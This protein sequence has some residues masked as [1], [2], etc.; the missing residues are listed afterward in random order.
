VT[1]LHE[2]TPSIPTLAP[3]AA[4]NA[5][6]PRLAADDP[7]PAVAD[8]ATPGTTSGSGDVPADLRP[9]ARRARAD[10]AATRELASALLGRH[11]E[12]D[13][14]ALA[15]GMD[16]DSVAS[17]AEVLR[18]GTAAAFVADDVVARA[19]SRSVPTPRVS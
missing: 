9:L 3:P 18:P 11:W 14:V 6:E 13:L 8:T 5:P 19:Q 2:P 16:P 15:T 12:A 4:A 10:S 1:V 7:T 17:L